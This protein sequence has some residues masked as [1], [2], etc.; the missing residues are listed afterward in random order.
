M[1]Y[2]DRFKNALD[3]ARRADAHFTAGTDISLLESSELAKL[4]SE[5][6]GFRSISGGSLDLAPNKL[7]LQQQASY[8]LWRR[9][10]LAQRLIDVN[11]DFIVGDG[12]SVIAIHEE[13]AKSDA[14]QEVINEFW[15]DP[16]NDMADTMEQKATELLLWGEVCMPFRSNEVNGMP[17]LG[18]VNPLEI[19]G[20]EA[21]PLTGEPWK[22]ELSDSAAE[23]VKQKYLEVVH[24]D[25]Q[26][27]TW[28]GD[29]FYTSMR[30]LRGMS[31]GVPELAVALTWMNTL[32]QTLTFPD[33]SLDLSL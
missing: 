14:I 17:R 23:Q 13:K 29:C 5:V 27:N 26:A 8:D 33:L 11:V 24:F 25:E 9:N 4:V 7:R 31:R 20:V 16:V 21:H 19:A 3:I 1:G 30:N 6:D 15:Y 2:L 12:I 18:W 10:L 22:I 32:D 28:I